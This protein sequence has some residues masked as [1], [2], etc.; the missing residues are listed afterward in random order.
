MGLKIIATEA[1]NRE[2]I[3]GCGDYSRFLA[4]MAMELK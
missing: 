4:S 1:Y 3:L 2:G